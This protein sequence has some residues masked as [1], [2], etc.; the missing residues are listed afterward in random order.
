MNSYQKG[1]RFEYRVLQ[2]LRKR[3]MLA[4][5]FPGSRPFD[6]FAVDREGRA[7]I[8]E[9][10]WRRQDFT[11]EEAETLALLRKVYRVKTLLAYNDRGRVVFEE[12][13]E[14]GR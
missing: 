14:G 13:G 2:S 9:C 6:V 10:K 4:F 11:R 1:R 12:V 8:I 7:Y 5:R 3:G